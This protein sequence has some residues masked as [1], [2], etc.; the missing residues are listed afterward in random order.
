MHPD[1]P[2]RGTSTAEVKYRPLKS[3]RSLSRHIPSKAARFQSLLFLTTI[4]HSAVSMVTKNRLMR[5][6]HGR[7]YLFSLSPSG[8][9]RV[10]VSEM[11]TLKIEIPLQLMTT[12]G[13]AL[14]SQKTQVVAQPALQKTTHHNPMKICFFHSYHIYRVYLINNEIGARAAPQRALEHQKNASMGNSCTWHS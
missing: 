9:L 2:L 14:R 7:F 12:Y 4:R 13:Y 5:N 3:A 11:N 8:L 10:R 6:M 1:F